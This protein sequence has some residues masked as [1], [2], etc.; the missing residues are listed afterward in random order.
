MLCGYGVASD[1]LNVVYVLCLVDVH[2]CVGNLC[3]LFVTSVSV[4]KTIT[5]GVVLQIAPEVTALGSC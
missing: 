3:C 2:K 4:K 5:Y 1:K